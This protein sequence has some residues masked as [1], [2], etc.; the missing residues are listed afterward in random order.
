MTIWKMRVLAFLIC[1]SLSPAVRY[2]TPATLMPTTPRIPTPADSISSVKLRMCQI[3]PSSSLQ[4][5]MLVSAPPQVAANTG[6][7]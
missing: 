3:P 6:V 7:L 4:L 5:M 2:W 1:C